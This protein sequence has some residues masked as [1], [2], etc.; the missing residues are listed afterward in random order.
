MSTFVPIDANGGMMLQ[1]GPGPLAAGPGPFPARNNPPSSCPCLSLS[2]LSLSAA[3][4]A[5]EETMNAAAVAAMST[6]FA[7]LDN[8]LMLA[9]F[10]ND[11]CSLRILSMR[12]PT[13]SLP[14]THESRTAN[15]SYKLSRD[16][17]VPYHSRIN[18]RRK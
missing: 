5:A 16:G 1:P 9:L 4:A 11:W 15:K 8:L 3:D 12:F 10:R 17:W 13:D 6:A 2:W 7:R 18:W 14:L